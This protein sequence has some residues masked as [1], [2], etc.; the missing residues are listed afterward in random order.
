VSHLKVYHRRDTPKQW[1]YRD[2][3]RVPPI[4]GTMEEGWQILRRGQ[5]EAIDGGRAPISGGQHGCDPRA[6]SMRGLLVAVGPV[7]RQGVVVDAFENVS[8][9]NVL[10]RVLAVPPARNDRDPKVARRLLREP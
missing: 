3:P 5:A 1:R 8:I 2:H 10:A 9:Y 7:F 6:A 4:V